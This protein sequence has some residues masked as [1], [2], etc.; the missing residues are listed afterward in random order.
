MLNYY[1]RPG[2]CRHE[3]EQRNKN[4]KIEKLTSK[5]L[6]GNEVWNKT[7]KPIPS[8]NGIKVDGKILETYVGEYEISHEFTMSVTK[9]QGKLF[10][11]GTGQDKLEM[12]ADTETKF[13]VKVNDAQFEFVKDD[14]GKVIKAILNQGGRQADAKKIK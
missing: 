13:F 5:K 4:D 10:L 7:N 8:E 3:P 6:N 12:F 11:Q 1:L 2:S 9:E 14:S